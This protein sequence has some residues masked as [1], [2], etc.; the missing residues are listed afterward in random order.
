MSLLG[1][2]QPICQ[3]CPFSAHC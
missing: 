2:S 1:E 3:V